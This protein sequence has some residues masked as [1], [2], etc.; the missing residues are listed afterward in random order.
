MEI[1]LSFHGRL[2][3][4]RPLLTKIQTRTPFFFDF[5]GVVKKKSP[6]HL[7]YSKGEGVVFL[8]AE[9]YVEGLPIMSVR[10]KFSNPPWSE[11]SDSGG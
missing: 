1:N 10:K 4:L 9:P 5:L 11:K 7:G 3:M 2:D 8:T 6:R